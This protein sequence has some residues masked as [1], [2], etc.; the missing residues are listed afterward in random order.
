MGY[1]FK[2]VT[3]LTMDDQQPHTVVGDLLVEGRKISRIAKNIPKMAHKVIEEEG[4]ILMPGFFNTHTH[5]SMSL[6]RGYG[7]D[8]PLFPWLKERI[9]P[10]EARL[11]KDDVEL[12]ARL[13][14]AEMLLSGTTSFLDMYQDMERVAKAV[15]ETGI[16]GHLS[17]GTIYSGDKKKDK[18]AI[19]ELTALAQEWHGHDQGRIRILAGPHAIYTSQEA[20]LKEQLEVAKAFGLGLNIHVAETREEV[21]DIRKAH[22]LSP[23]EYLKKTGVLEAPYVIAAHMVHLEDADR[24][25]AA[26]YGVGIAHN[27]KSNL[28]LGSG[29]ADILGCRNAGLK[30]GIGTD[31]AASNNTQDM[32]EELRMAALLQKGMNHDPTVFPAYEI[33]KMATLGGAEVM[34]IQDEVG[35]LREGYEADLIAFQR[36]GPNMRPMSADPAALIAYSAKSSDICLT[37]V[38][39]KMLMRDRKFLTMD[40]EGLYGPLEEALSR[41]T[42]V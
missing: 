28:K 37:M 33:L 40:L 41:I 11:T 19:R 35:M 9:W 29:I 8:M 36:K 6:F 1:L 10:A 3:M 14:I 16:R 4:L 39:G 26:E 12:G 13:G 24:S 2:N 27:P 42:S 38:A 32:V 21:A 25:I 23:M 34:G 18:A 31:G 20:F 7:D 30:I 15:S 5:I 22:G 17:R